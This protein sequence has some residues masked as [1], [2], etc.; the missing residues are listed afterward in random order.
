MAA[1]AAKGTDVLPPEEVK[2]IAALSDAK[3]AID[4]ARANEDV[5]SLLEWRDKAAAAQ[6]YIKRRDEARELA[7]NAGELKVR[8]EAALGRLDL[9]TSPGPGR[10]KQAEDEKATPAVVN[11][12]ADF[13]PN[14]RSAFR[15]LGRLDSEQLDEVVDKLRSDDDGGVTTSRAVKR[16]REI[17]PIEHREGREPGKPTGEQRKELVRDYA[18][19]VK[20]LDTQVSLCTRLAK[21][22]IAAGTPG[23]R[24]RVAVRLT[25]II[26]RAENLRDELEVDGAEALV[27][28]DVED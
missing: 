8:A 11:P 24:Q 15:T 7:D 26:T 2:A 10:P 16:A 4:I 5:A 12:L 19:H 9:D 27:G 22:F 23:E 21:K 6:H 17:L 3:T 1:T 20:A 25:N 18:G 13:Q 14:T 28:D